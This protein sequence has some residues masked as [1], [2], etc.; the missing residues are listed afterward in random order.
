MCVACPMCA[1]VTMIVTLY[2]G[3]SMITS[4]LVCKTMHHSPA[5]AVLDHST[6][7][8]S[9]LHSSHPSNSIHTSQQPLHITTLN[10]SHALTSREHSLSN[11]ISHQL[12]KLLPH[13]TNNYIP[14]NTGNG[15]QRRSSSVTNVPSVTTIATSAGDCHVQVLPSHL[16]G[17]YI[18]FCFCFFFFF[19]LHLWH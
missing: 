9:Y 16:T 14:G 7:T 11:F 10:V 13:V 6:Q 12:S 18:D 8:L 1:I 17:D 2:A 15:L 4:M 3:E 19:K 5:C